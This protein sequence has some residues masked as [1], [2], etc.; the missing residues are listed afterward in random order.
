MRLY[1]VRHG[2]TSWN[3]E[4]R[5]QGHSDT[6]LDE[7][8]QAQARSLVAAFSGVEVKTVLSSDLKRCVQ[9]AA[10]VAEA[11]GTDV[12]HLRDLRER[13]FGAL[14]GSP[15]EEVREY[16]SRMSAEQG[17][18]PHMVRT[19]GGESLHDVSL[20]VENVAARLGREGPT[21]VVSHGGALGLLI[22]RLIGAAPEVAR[23]FRLANGSITEIERRNDGAWQIVRLNDCSH[24]E[25]ALEGFGAGT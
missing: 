15:Y 7:T 17:I 10:C 24:L 23:A 16:V 8:G 12:E 13:C 25:E 14:E 2:Q 20:R 22:A 5:A 11:T 19:E 18:D 1:L 3:R 4:R 9:T 6:E 21:V